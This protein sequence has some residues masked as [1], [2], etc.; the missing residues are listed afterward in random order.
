MCI[1]QK[2]HDYLKA[3]KKAKKISN[4]FQKSFWS[5]V[6]PFLSTSSV[7]LALSRVY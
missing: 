4:S 2:S 6:L 5:T 3:L 1:Y 7:E